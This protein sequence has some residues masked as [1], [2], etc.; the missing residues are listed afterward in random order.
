[1]LQSL[2][3]VPMATFYH[4]PW[5]WG[6]SLVPRVSISKNTAI[7]QRI[8]RANWNFTQLLANMGELPLGAYPGGVYMGNI[9]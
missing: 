5:Q 6:A 7:Y 3:T 4:L 8:R 9:G 2:A 1:V